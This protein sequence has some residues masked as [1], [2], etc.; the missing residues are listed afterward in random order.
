MNREMK[1]LR[2]MGVFEL[3]PR[4]DFP[5]GK[6]VIKTRFVY[7]IKQ[8]SDGTIKKYKSRLISQVFLLRYGIDYYDIYS[9]VVGYSSLRTL[10]AISANTA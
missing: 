5:N 2:D 3:I 8:N 4:R 10:I 6:K 7:K 9:S 1:A